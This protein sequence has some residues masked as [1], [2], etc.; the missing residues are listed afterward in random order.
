[1]GR[2]ATLNKMDGIGVTD[3]VAFESRF[4]GGE[5]GSFVGAQGTG[6]QAD[7]VAGMKVQM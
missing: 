6:V 2:V 7:E 4:G 3:K 5:G 1:M